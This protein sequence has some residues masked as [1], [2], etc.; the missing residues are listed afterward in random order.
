M[1]DKIKLASL[2]KFDIAEY[3]D[4]SEAI[5]EYLSDAVAIAAEKGDA[6]V[7]AVALGNVARARGMG[8]IATAAGLGRESLY[9]ALREGSQPRFDT[10]QK[11]IA[12]LGLKLDVKVA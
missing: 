10:V 6:S 7:L 8:E 2:R 5:A 3:L 1:A 12:A 11:V 4:D 9:K